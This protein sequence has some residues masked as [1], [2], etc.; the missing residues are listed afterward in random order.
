MIQICIMHHFLTSMIERAL[1]ARIKRPNFCFCWTFYSLFVFFFSTMCFNFCYYIFFI[2]K[3]VFFS[4]ALG[5]K[6]IISRVLPS[7]PLQM[8][9]LCHAPYCRPDEMEA[10][11]K[12]SVLLLLMMV[13]AFHHLFHMLLCFWTMG[14]FFFAPFYLIL[15]ASNSKNC[16]D[17]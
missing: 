17:K 10:N 11:L 5:R 6:C 14:L 15:L 3:F 2:S 4:F 12:D 7:N 8:M 16:A 1:W 9:R 13:F